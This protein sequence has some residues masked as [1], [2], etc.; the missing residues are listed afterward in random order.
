MT[1]LQSR[2]KTI[3]RRRGDDLGGAPAVVAP[4]ALAKAR[5]YLEDS[6]VYAATR[7]VWIATTAYDHPAT[8]GQTLLWGIR[9]LVVKRTVEVRIGGRP[10]AR[11]LVLFST[12]SGTHGGEV[13]PETPEDV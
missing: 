7:P 5:N 13:E 3:I 10:V 2:F 11:L 1:R 6:A 9:S 4:L 12:S 8:E